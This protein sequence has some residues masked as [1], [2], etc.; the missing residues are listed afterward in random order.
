MAVPR[1]PSTGTRWLGDHL[2][3][4][5]KYILSKA[6]RM[7]KTPTHP[8][9]PS[10]GSSESLDGFEMHYTKT[11]AQSDSKNESSLRTWRCSIPFPNVHPDIVIGALWNF[12]YKWDPE[13]ESCHLEDQLTDQIQLCRVG[14]RTCHA[15]NIRWARLLRGHLTSASSAITTTELFD[16]APSPPSLLS[17]STPPS[18]SFSPA[19]S[20][21][22]HRTTAKTMASSPVI[23]SSSSG[24]LAFRPTLM[25]GS[26]WVR[27]IYV[28]E[29]IDR[30]KTPNPARRFIKGRNQRCRRL[31]GSNETPG[32]DSL[33]PTLS[34]TC[35]Y[36]EHLLAERAP[37]AFGC[38][39][40]IVSKI[41]LG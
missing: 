21:S 23:V 17:L 18:S 37:G 34:M 31:S 3:C 19:T 28:S 6:R 8:S 11:P 7:Q 35:V 38:R 33:W 24:H 25:P 29:S 15:Q 32:W 12:R 39:V 22:G 20:S 27:A 2:D 26:D 5:M 40:S 4:A 1:M 41:D 16:C 14:F 30:T 9:A 10:F 36:K 13:I